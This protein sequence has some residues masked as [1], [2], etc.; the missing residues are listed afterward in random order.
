[1]H[2]YIYATLDFFLGEAGACAYACLCVQ[3]YTCVCVR[4]HAYAHL[5]FFYV[6]NCVRVCKHMHTLQPYH[7]F[8]YRYCAT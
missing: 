5:S 4:V 8:R 1:M 2:V 6:Y 3:I 7:C